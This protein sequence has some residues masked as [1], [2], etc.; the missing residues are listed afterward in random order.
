MDRRRRACCFN[1]YPQESRLPN[2]RLDQVKRY[3]SRNRQYKAGKAGA[4]SQINARPRGEWNQRPEL[5][6]IRE[7]ALPKIIDRMA[8]NQIDASI[9]PNQQRGV[10]LEAVACFT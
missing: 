4:R 8:P 1:D 9:P 2:I 6:A 7:V 5:K 3:T 10:G